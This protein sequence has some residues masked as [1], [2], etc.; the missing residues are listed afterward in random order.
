MN[1]IVLKL[2]QLGFSPYEAK[3]YYALLRKH[4]SNGYEI[5]KIGKI[6]AA[7]I[8]DTLNRL[9]LK[10]VVVESG[11]EAGRY[12]P[13][14]PETLIAKVKGDFTGLIDSLELQLK[15]TE[16]IAD[17][18]LTMNFSGYDA[19]ADRMLGTIAGCR[20]FLLLSLWPEEAALLAEAIAC[21]HRRG[22][23]V[24]AGVFGACPLECSYFVDLEQC[25]RTARRRLHRRLCA[26]VSDSREVVIAE[27]D[28]AGAEGIWTTTPGVVLVTKEYVKHDIWGN[29]LVAALGENAFRTLCEQDRLLSYLINTR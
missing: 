6:P 10:G 24:V 3:A 22:V 17:I 19:V 18:D 1:D 5:S 27:I 7:K 15:A 9:K 13:V 25:G 8:Y 28:D 23:I 14:P 29:A 4:P 2:E 20:S 12:Y 16:P 21:A 26:V 11:T